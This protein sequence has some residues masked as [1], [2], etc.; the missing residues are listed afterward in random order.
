MLAARFLC[1]FHILS[2]VRKQSKYRNCMAGVSRNMQIHGVSRNRGLANFRTISIYKKVRT[3]KI[4][5]K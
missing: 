2:R 3:R 1:A 4:G 5:A